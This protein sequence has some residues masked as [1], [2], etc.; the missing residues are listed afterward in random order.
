MTPLTLSGRALVLVALAVLGA[1]LGKWLDPDKGGYVDSF[2]TKITTSDKLY[3][4]C[5]G[6]LLMFA[7]ARVM[8]PVWAFAGVVVAG[9]SWEL[10]QGTFSWR[11]WVSDI[12]GA[13]VAF[14]V[15]VVT[16]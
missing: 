13:G 12:A 4:A 3:H 15:L 5:L 11:D 14:G 8:P 7:L 6:A 16:A 9:G 1:V 10:G 2:T